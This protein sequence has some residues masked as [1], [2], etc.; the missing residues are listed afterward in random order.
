MQRAIIKGNLGRDAETVTTSSDRQQLAFTVACSERK[1]NEKITTWYDVLYHNVKLQPYL[2][3]GKEVVVTGRLALQSY[4]AKDGTTRTA[5]RIFAD[6]VEMCGNSESGGAARNE[7][8]TTR[9]SHRP[10]GGPM[11]D[12]VRQA[13]SLDGGDSGLPF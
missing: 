10:G 9:A 2:N 1:N 11:G 4:Q 6:A 12:G 7:D 13:Q 3:K 8:A 5:L